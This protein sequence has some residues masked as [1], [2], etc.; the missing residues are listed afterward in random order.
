MNLGSHGS[1]YYLRVLF[2][3]KIIED[4]APDMNKGGEGLKCLMKLASEGGIEVI[5]AKF[6][7]R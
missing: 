5:T 1:R 7:D 3:F 2:L 4:I 6:E